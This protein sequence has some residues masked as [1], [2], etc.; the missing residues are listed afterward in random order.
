[1][2][3]YYSGP[4]PTGSTSSSTAAATTTKSSSA[5]TS[6]PSG[7]KYGGCYVDGTYGR[8]MQNQQADNQQLTVE[9]CV[10]TCTGLG[11]SVAGIEYG[12]QWFVTSLSDLNIDS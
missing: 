5:A 12:E 10:Q 9:S 2:Y 7:W 4:T 11:Y 6:L 8:I 1:M 3:S